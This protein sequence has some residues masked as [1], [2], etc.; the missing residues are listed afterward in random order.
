[1]GDQLADFL[2]HRK[3]HAPV[4]DVDWQAKKDAWVHSVEK[5]YQLVRDMFR[6]SIASDY[7]TVRT[8][9]TEVTEDFIGTYSIPGLGLRIGSERVEFRPKGVTVIGVEGRVDMRGD[10]EVLTL[11]KEQAGDR[12][13]WSIVLQRVPHFRTVP[14]DQESLTHA[15]ERVMLPLP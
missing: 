11:I 6:E 4:P 15:L 14:L 2:R 5:L 12:N 13:G 3:E 1:M 7:V 8:F 9:D 10:R